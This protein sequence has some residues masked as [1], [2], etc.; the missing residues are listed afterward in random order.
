[1]ADPRAIA[2]W[3]VRPDEDG[4]V[5]ERF[6]CA[7]VPSEP[8]ERVRSAIA[9]RVRVSWAA[10]VD[11]SDPVPSGGQVR[12]L[13]EPLHEV[14][15]GRPLRIVV[16]RDGWLAV[17]KPAGIPVHPS[18]SIRANSLIERIRR[19]REEPGLRLAHRLDRETSGVLLLARDRATAARLGKAF[20]R[21]AVVK[22]YVAVVHGVPYADEGTVD[23]AL[24]RAVASAVQVRQS[25]GHGRESR[26]R[27][28][29][30]RRGRQRAV[31]RLVPET[32]RRHQLRAHLEAIGHPIVGDVLYGRP[33]R[34]YLDLVNGVRD[35][36]IDA[37]E[38]AR[39]MLHCRGVRLGW[40]GLDIDVR[41]EPPGDFEAAARSA[42]RLD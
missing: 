2:H 25:A 9:T 4:M 38:P 29:V 12:L 36:R 6:L 8:I 33:D 24:G 15:D 11:R 23:L 32:G 26:T 18:R 31:L 3:I 27:W 14:P 28:A 16:E 40:P 21:R 10:E 34:D 37:G 39:M 22:E 42:G 41:V 20:E 17:D 19:T 30:E 7:R 5:L 1:M 13:P 35:P